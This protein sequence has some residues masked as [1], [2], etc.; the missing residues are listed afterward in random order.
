MKLTD[1]EIAEKAR[2]LFAGMS[3]EK[4]AFIITMKVI[5]RNV[6]LI[7]EYHD[8]E[9]VKDEKNSSIVLIGGKR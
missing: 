8:G 2:E 3:P 4:I 5:P 1:Q 7:V 9:F 6:V